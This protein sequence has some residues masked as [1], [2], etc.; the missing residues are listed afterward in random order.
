M[1]KDLDSITVNYKDFPRL[2]EPDIYDLGCVKNQIFRFLDKTDSQTA[3]FFLTGD[4]SGKIDLSQLSVYQLFGIYTEHA[5]I[6]SNSK[7]Y[8]LILEADDLRNESA[9]EL[10]ID[11]QKLKYGCTV[12]N[13]VVIKKVYSSDVEREDDNSLLFQVLPD[14]TVF[15]KGFSKKETRVACT[16]KFANKSRYVN[17]ADLFDGLTFNSSVPSLNILNV[18][19]VFKKMLAYK[20]EK[21]IFYCDDLDP[22]GPT[23]ASYCKY[24]V[25]AIAAYLAL[26]QEYHF[27]FSKA[28]DENFLLSARELLSRDYNYTDCY[29]DFIKNP[30][31]VGFKMIDQRMY[32]MI[33]DDNAIQR[34]PA[35]Y[36][37]EV[38]ILG[39]PFDLDT[40]SIKNTK[41]E[42]KVY[43]LDVL[44]YGSLEQ[45]FS[46]D[47]SDWNTAVQG[48]N[49]LGKLFNTFEKLLK[50]NSFGVTEPLFLNNTILFREEDEW[51][52]GYVHGLTGKVPYVAVDA[53]Y[54]H[55]PFKMVCDVSK[56]NS[57]YDTNLLTDRNV[58]ARLI[59]K[60]N[61][62]GGVI[63][64]YQLPKSSR[65]IIFKNLLTRA[66]GLK[67]DCG[68][69]VEELGLWSTT[70]S[71]L[72]LNGAA[73]ILRY[74]ALESAR[75]SKLLTCFGGPH[76]AI[77]VNIVLGEDNG[78]RYV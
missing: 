1:Q 78:G 36:T 6:I 58:I 59:K 46:V 43:S 77:S 13:Y 48:V 40:R 75:R 29:F 30:L 4:E 7:N 57:I 39:V 66:N 64:H 8:L 22:A 16:L 28:D 31:N 24:V 27:E 56:L 14:V 17:M 74:V 60:T 10:A 55:K 65:G 70:T 49:E 9:L 73:S 63:E 33:R 45:C 62:G 69:T 5:D 67:E 72:R 34:N 32:I 25:T 71:Q 53:D 11:Q 38:S 37:T 52:I 54:R 20:G 41:I 35:E 47:S 50:K 21:V 51:F 76:Q 68:A 12:F 42:R 23:N 18:G 19:K 61:W 15:N 2:D 26:T 3:N 44:D